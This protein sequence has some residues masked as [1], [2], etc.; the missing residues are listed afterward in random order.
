M[1]FFVIRSHFFAL[2]DEQFLPRSLTN[3]R[4]ICIMGEEM[5]NERRTANVRG[6]YPPFDE[7][8]NW[9]DDIFWFDFSCSPKRGLHLSLSQ[10]KEKEKK[11]KRQKEKQLQQNQ[12]MI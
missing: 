2:R 7:G 8:G 1:C 3:A 11:E 6:N 4:F 9:N 12:K 5:R 10:R